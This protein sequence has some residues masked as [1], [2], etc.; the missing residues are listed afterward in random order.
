MCDEDLR[1]TAYHE[2]GHA[3]A[4]YAVG[5]KFVRASIV[6][7]D[8]A[9]GSVLHTGLSESTWD[10]LESGNTSDLRIRSLREK[11]IICAYAGIAA[12]EIVYESSEYERAESD[13]TT[14]SNH[15]FKVASGEEEAGAYAEWLRIRTLNMLRK[16]EWLEALHA[17]ANALLQC[18]TLSYR[19][20]RRIIRDA[21]QGAYGRYGI[22]SS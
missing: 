6:E 9:A 3:V 20:T 10:R 4:S 18:N 8:E 2:A 21:I 16:P 5:R 11:E 1:R 17:V 12:E 19:R 13:R 22:S 15:V 7:S 14:I